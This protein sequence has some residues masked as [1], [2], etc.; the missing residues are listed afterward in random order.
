M[1]LFEGL[2]T[3]TEPLTS[4]TVAIGTFDG[5][6]VGHQAIIRA[7]TRDAGENGRTSLVF[8]FDRHPADLLAPGRAPDYLTT[9]Q[10]RNLYVAELGVDGLVV[11]AFDW[12]LAELSPDAFVERILISQLGA[13]AVVV[14]ENF[15]FG[16]NRSGNVTYLT[17]AQERFGFELRTL[18]PI[19]VAGLPASSTRVRE[20]LRAGAIQEAEHVLGHAYRLAGTVV[21]GQKLGRKL[22]YPTANLALNCRQVVPQDG[23]YAVRA[24][25]DDGCVVDGA[26]SI[27]VR[28]T[29]PGAG[30]SIET[31]L[32]DFDGDL[33][34]RSMEIR[35]VRRLRD[36]LKFD[37][38]DALKTQMAGDVELARRILATQ[39]D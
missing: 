6:H 31:F 4:S 5:I 22:G 39:D 14:G 3:L 8:T 7:A 25:L 36:E 28:P 18:D 26:C 2:E 27:G 24:R 20:L 21:E 1:K 12:A 33:Y 15:S 29:I 17:E 38:L 19:I 37:S 32:L 9:P 16:K 11:A 34:G 35:F 30:H 23:I 10:Q 13:K